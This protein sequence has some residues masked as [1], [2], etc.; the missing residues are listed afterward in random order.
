MTQKTEV[1]KKGLQT[2]H[3]I[4]I[5]GSL[6]IICAA[7][8]IGIMMF[9]DKPETITPVANANNLEEIKGE[10]K[11]KV[12]KGMFMTHMNTTW[13]FPDGKSASKNA[14]MGNSTGNSYPFWFTVTLTDTKEELYKSGVLPV[15]QQLAEIK[16][17][18]ALAKGTYPAYI[19]IHLVDENGKELDSNMNFNITIIV[20]N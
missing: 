10:I 9:R 15:G 4:L 5:F 16:L 3:I 7:V 17:S 14:V 2:K 12:A 18:K 1:T 6:I 19:T 8:I 13:N 20:E 11:D